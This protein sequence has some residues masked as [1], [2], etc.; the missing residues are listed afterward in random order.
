M[1]V[2]HDGSRVALAL[3]DKT[4]QILDVGT[5]H[6]QKGIALSDKPS[7]IAWSPDGRL[8]VSTLD[9]RVTLWAASGEAVREIARMDD[10]QYYEALDFSPDGQRLAGAGTDKS[11]RVWTTMDGRE[12]GHTCAANDEVRSRSVRAGRQT[13]GNRGTGPDRAALESG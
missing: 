12:R 1:A 4:V 7:A 3:E 6:S 9:G 13:P 10:R 11:V 8:A 2:S 5:G